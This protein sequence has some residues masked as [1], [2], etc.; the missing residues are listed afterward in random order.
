[1][2]REELISRLTE[3]REETLRCFIMDE[4]QLELS[5]SP[6]KWTVKEILIH[7]ADAESVLLERIKRIIAEP[8]QVLWAFDQDQW[9]KN[10]EYESYP[11]QL[12]A[13]QYKACRDVSIYL[14]NKYFDQYGNKEFVHSATGLRTLREE[15]I[16]IAEHNL[17]HLAQI[18]QIL[19]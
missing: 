18:R 8:K 1:M 19:K 7:L 17:N 13:N 15:M 10:L 4:A 3:S 5:L 12:A 11:L 16:K 14:C 2:E 6:D 9:A